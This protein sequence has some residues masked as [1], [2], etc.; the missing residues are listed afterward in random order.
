MSEVRK[1]RLQAGEQSL[2][3]GIINPRADSAQTVAGPQHLRVGFAY[4]IA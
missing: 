2:S 1:P 3:G 4:M